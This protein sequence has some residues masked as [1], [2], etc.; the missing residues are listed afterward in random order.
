M[1]DCG[2]RSMTSQQA[3]RDM[4][5]TLAMQITEKFCQG[6]NASML[7]YGQTGSGKVGLLSGGHDWMS[8]A[9]LDGAS[10]QGRTC[11]DV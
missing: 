8:Q 11:F 2:L 6:F 1:T 7:A 3:S 10:I 9:R 5:R 4:F